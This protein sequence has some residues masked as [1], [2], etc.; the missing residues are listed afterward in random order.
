MVYRCREKETWSYIVQCEMLYE[1][2]NKF[3][4]EVVKNIRTKACN[5][6][7]KQVVDDINQ[8]LR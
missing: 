8:D 3:I 5:E 1:I 2:N 6:E 4:S 7:Q